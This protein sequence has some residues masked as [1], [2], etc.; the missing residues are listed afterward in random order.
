MPAENLG[1]VIVIATGNR[2]KVK[3]FAKW[4][5]PLGVEVK[6]L[7]DFEGIPDIVEDGA[8]FAENAMIKARVVAEHLGIPVL[9][10]DSGL[11]VDALDGR[12]GVY[13]ARYAGEGATDALNNRKL[14][15]ELRSLNPLRDIAEAELAQASYT[16]EEA[17]DLVP[18]E[19]L[20]RAEFRCA[21][22]MVDPVRGR[23]VEAEGACE[24]WII[25][26][27]R[28]DG[29]FGYDPHFYLPAFGLTM[30]QL[31]IEEKNKISHRAA[32]LRHFMELYKA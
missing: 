17:P 25:A 14:V 23:T 3:E 29:G 16:V 30:A 11:C 26:E 8:T 32:A 5:E 22:A 12:P 31:P 20:S 24:G 2:G 6:S 1:K 10:D 9:A 4:F 27:P 21:L 28:G 18:P 7:A 19:E 15:N 13:S